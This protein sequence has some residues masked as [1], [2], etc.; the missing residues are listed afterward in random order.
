MNPFL[1]QHYV[2]V[3][4]AVYREGPTI[5]TL[6]LKGSFYSLRAE[7]IFKKIHC[8]NENDIIYNSM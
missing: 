6:I 4:Y 8:F 3:A 7:L 2:G 1:V 5:G